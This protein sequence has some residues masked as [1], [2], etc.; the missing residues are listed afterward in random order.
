MKFK[1]IISA[2]LFILFITSTTSAYAATPTYGTN[3][4]LIYQ[5]NKYVPAIKSNA[6][7][8]CIFWSDVIVPQNN[9]YYMYL[10]TVE[11][12]G[13]VINKSNVQYK[14]SAYNSFFALYTCNNRFAVKGKYKVKLYVKKYKTNDPWVVAAS[15]NVVVY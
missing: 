11:Y 7:A 4:I 13:K 14:L 2:M 5:G 6:T 15:R 12:N 8:N 3:Q 9:V 1:K 10:W